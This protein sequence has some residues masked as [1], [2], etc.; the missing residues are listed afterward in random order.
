MAYK[1]VK[2]HALGHLMVAHLRA[3]TSS[4]ELS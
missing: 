3:A 1:N 4:T 2:A